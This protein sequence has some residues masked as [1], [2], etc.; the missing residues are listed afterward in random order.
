MS[1]LLLSGPCVVH[2]VETIQEH[3]DQET[4]PG[5]ITREGDNILNQETQALLHH[6]NTTAPEAEVGYLITTLYHL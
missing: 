2:M 1:F 5:D 4:P 3:S 6:G